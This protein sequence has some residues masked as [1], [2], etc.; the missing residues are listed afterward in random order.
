MH[1]QLALCRSSTRLYG[2]TSAG[3]P[4][5]AQRRVSQ[6]LQ[7]RHCQPLEWSRLARLGCLFMLS[8][9]NLYC[10]SSGSVI[11]IFSSPLPLATSPHPDHLRTRWTVRD[12]LQ[13][14][15]QQNPARAT[16]FV[17]LKQIDGCQITSPLPNDALRP[18]GGFCLCPPTRRQ[19]ITGSRAI[20]RICLPS[21]ERDPWASGL[22]RILYRSWT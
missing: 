19:G 15:P 10:D 7:Q 11:I 3:A 17:G 18:G 1:L 12:S 2:L 8:T 6:P 16:E 20:D 9:S 5:Q 14:P 21:P 4:N 22:A 13:P